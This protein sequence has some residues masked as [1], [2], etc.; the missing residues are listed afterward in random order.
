MSEKN[1]GTESVTRGR[2]F[3]AFNRK[4]YEQEQLDR[5]FMSNQEFAKTDCEYPIINE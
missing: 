2:T 3:L 5:K 4:F 1:V